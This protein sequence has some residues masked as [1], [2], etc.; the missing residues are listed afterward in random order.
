MNVEYVLLVV[1]AFASSIKALIQGS[2]SR[3]HMKN[4]QDALMYNCVMFAAAALIFA[5]CFVFSG[6]KLPS[7][8]TVFL[9]SC[10]GFC[11]LFFQ[12]FYSKALARGSVSL[13]AMINNFSLL[14]PITLGALAFG[15]KISV[16]Q[17]CG[18]A[19]FAAAMML[20]VSPEN[21]K[22]ND[23]KWLLMTLTCM[24][25]S[26]TVAMVQKI[27]QHTA[28]A[29]ESF[30]F[31][32]IANLSALIFSGIVYLVKDRQGK[33]KRTVPLTMNIIAPILLVGL[34]LGVYHLMSLYLN[35][36]IDSV[37]MYP[38]TNVA[39]LMFITFWGVV[40]FKDK[41]PFKKILALLVG[42]ASIV[43]INLKF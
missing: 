15:E 17:I 22:K 31:I 1:M 40:I 3:K 39:N 5:V 36:V 26:G 12:L 4:S 19:L 24:T 42:A 35:G 21:G 43:L 29:G 16:L 32:V 38:V 37:I 30:G 10:M 14:L 34:I 9:A 27:H 8:A 6:E 13:T 33:E 11:S 18:V 7:L 23:I 20:T 25:A 2:F 41:L 28:A